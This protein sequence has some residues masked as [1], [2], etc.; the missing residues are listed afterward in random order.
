MGASAIFSAGAYTVAAV[1]APPTRG[2]LIGAAVASAAIG[3][4]TAI[5]MMPTNN[6]L[7]KL[8]EGAVVAQTEEV[9]ALLK[10]WKGMHT[11]RLMLGGIGYSLGLVAL[12]LSL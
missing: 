11:V 7:I 12:L 5:V 10:K 8:Q 6:R 2:P 1:L 3:A 4:Y 9:E